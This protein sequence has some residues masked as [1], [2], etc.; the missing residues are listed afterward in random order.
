ARSLRKKNKWG[1]KVVAADGGLQISVIS[2]IE[3]GKRKIYRETQEKLFKGLGVTR[4]Q[5]FDTD[6]LRSFEGINQRP[7]LGEVCCRKCLET[8]ET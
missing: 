4:A 1:Q 7:C 5:F 6:E 3:N 8:A 2:A